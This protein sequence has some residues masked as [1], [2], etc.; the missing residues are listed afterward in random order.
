MRKLFAGLLLLFPVALFAQDESLAVDGDEEDANWRFDNGV[1]CLGAACNGAACD[2]RVDESP[3]ATDNL[4]VTTV[5]DGE[6]IFFDFPTP[7]NGP[8][9]SA[10]DQTFD[11]AVS[12]CGFD[13]DTGWCVENGGTDPNYDIAILCAGVLK[14]TIASAQAVSASN[15][16]DSHAWTFTSDGDCNAD[17]STVQVRITNHRSGGG[18]TGR[19][20]VCLEALEWEVTWAATG[21]RRMLT[22]GKDR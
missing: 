20:M 12:E 18:P 3:Q 22:V 4:L 19:R 5:T 16:N 8:S 13:T 1:D 10:S 7:T 2:D 14:T 15:Q 17:G 6:A 9:A 11:I 21:R